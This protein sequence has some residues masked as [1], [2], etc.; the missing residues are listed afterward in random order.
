MRPVDSQLA[1]ALLAG[2][3]GVIVGGWMNRSTERWR[4]RR[5]AR[6]AAYTDLLIAIG[7]LGEAADQLLD[8]IR[9][10]WPQHL[11]PTAPARQAAIATRRA[12]VLVE[13]LGS[14]T[15]IRLSEDPDLYALEA[16]I[17]VDDPKDFVRLW[18]GDGA[19]KPGN[20]SKLL[21]AEYRIR[22]RAHRE[23]A[24]LPIHERWRHWRTSI[25]RR[26]EKRRFRG[27]T[28]RP[29]TTYVRGED[30]RTVA[31]TSETPW[32][33]RSNRRA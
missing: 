31:P 17:N 22:D 24:P 9:H 25:S 18:Q 33:R 12:V 30:P 19:A 26:R 32:P 8:A 2:L 10:E 27:M 3:V 5:D 14:P 23:L 4:W 21:S 20:G 11:L 15:M 7:D 13:M 1:T 6:R 16:Q 28:S 29:R